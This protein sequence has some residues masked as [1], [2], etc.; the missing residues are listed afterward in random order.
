M[1]KT[2]SGMA[3][4]T[5]SERLDVSNLD[6]GMYFVRITGSNGMLETYKLVKE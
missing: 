4:D 2:Y 5:F 3:N 1:I 6:S